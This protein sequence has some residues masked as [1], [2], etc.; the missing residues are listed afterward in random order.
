MDV[1]WISE[2]LV[3]MSYCFSDV[4]I[5]TTG[6]A[7]PVKG[8]WEGA[9]F[10]RTKCIVVVSDVRKHTVVMM[11]RSLAHT[12]WAIYSCGLRN[13]RAFVL[14]PLRPPLRAGLWFL[15]GGLHQTVMSHDESSPDIDIY[16]LEV[17]P[18][19]FY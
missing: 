6:D 14:F 18:P 10:V 12:M 13:G 17:E 2:S 19:L 16:T 3:Q 5:H 15:G 4:S 1:S 8:G 9:G 7:N 11:W